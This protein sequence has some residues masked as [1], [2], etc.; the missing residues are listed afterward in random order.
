[1]RLQPT[2]DRIV[3]EPITEEEKPT[4]SGLVVVKTGRVDPPSRGR[5]VRVGPGRR[6]DQGVTLPPLVQVGDEVLFGKFAGTELK[7]DGQP[8]LLIRESDILAV[9]D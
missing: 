5:I 9:M 1:M 7:V 8:V 6:T 2:E 4:K 3:V